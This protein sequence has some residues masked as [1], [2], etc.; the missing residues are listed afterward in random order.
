MI[1]LPGIIPTELTDKYSIWLSRDK[2]VGKNNGTINAQSFMFLGVTGGGFDFNINYGGKILGVFERPPS[3]AIYMDEMGGA[4]SDIDITTV[5]VNPEDYDDR[6][7]K[8]AKN[9]GYTPPSSGRTLNNISNYALHQELVDMRTDIQL[10]GNAYV[11]R[12][13]RGMGNPFI[14]K[15]MKVVNS[16][17]PI[18]VAMR[19][20]VQFPVFFR[21]G[22]CSLEPGQPNQMNVR[23]QLF[24]R[25]P[26]V[27]FNNIE[28]IWYGD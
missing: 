16:D 25:N 8:V 2:I 17:I 5:R 28:E 24:M 6:W 23:L 3:R 15:D 13:Y 9:H 10:K 14:T 18:N 26:Y 7:T 20:Y 4:K 21:K 22:S 19:N 27:G 1:Q 12:I 11:L